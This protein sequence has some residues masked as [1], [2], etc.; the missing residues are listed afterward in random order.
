P[1]LCVGLLNRNRLGEGFGFGFFVESKLALD[2]VFD[3]KDMFAAKLAALKVR[4]TAMWS[5]RIRFDCVVRAAL[6]LRGNEPS[7]PTLLQLR[8]G[9]Y[10]K[11]FNFSCFHC[12]SPFLGKTQSEAYNLGCLGQTA[13]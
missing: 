10:F 6:T 7:I 5:C 2:H 13:S 11:A 8:F 4:A 12:E 1:F 9:R 3:C